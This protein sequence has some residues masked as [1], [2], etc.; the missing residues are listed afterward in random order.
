LTQNGCSPRREI[1]GAL[2]VDA[3]IHGGVFDVMERD[4]TYGGGKGE[5]RV[6]VRYSILACKN[7][8]WRR[9]LVIGCGRT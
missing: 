3:I 8:S 5:T 9:T 4:G 1:G 7:G 2:G 6:T